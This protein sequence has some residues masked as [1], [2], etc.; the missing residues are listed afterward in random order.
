LANHAPA[1]DDAP[2]WPQVEHHANSI[3]SNGGAVNPGDRRALY[4]IARTL[5]ADSVLEIGTHLGGSTAM[6]ALA[7]KYSPNPCLVS[8][9]IEDVNGPVGAWSMYGGQPPKELMSQLGCARF[10]TFVTSSSIDFMGSCEQRFDMIFLDGSHE[11][12][13]VYQEVP[14][15]VNL[16][17]P[18]GIILLH[19]FFP[20]LK[21]L[22]SNGKVIAGPWLAVERLKRRGAQIEGKAF[23]ALPWP[24][25][26]GSNVSSLACIVRK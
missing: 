26:L 18:G 15:A 11:A 24:T 23:G 25:K 7:L 21:P 5:R 20:R 2:E 4:A 6:F 22:W 3:A 14:L 8:V 16:L 1:V 10:V 13:V 12:A 9:D 19:D 17:N